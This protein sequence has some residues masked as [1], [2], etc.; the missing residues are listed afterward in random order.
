M[1]NAGDGTHEH[2]TQALLDIMTIRE[3]LG[4]VEDKTIAIVGDILHSRVARSNALALTTL[5]AHVRLIGP[6][7]LL[8]P[9]FDRRGVERYTDLHAGLDGVDAIMMLRLQ[10]ERQTRNFFPSL[11]EYARHFCLTV[12]ALKQAKPEVIILHPGPMNRGVEID[13]RVADG[14]YSVILEQVTN[15]VAVRMAVLYLLTTQE[16]IAASDQPAQASEL[17]TR[18]GQ[19]KQRMREER[20]QRQAKD[21]QGPRQASTPLSKRAVGQ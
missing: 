16:R 20:S 19:V 9:E 17:E 15:G 5:G 13:S 6:P 1:I 3:H 21:G 11:D 12:D 10:R 4:E 2:P 7:T 18:N 8:P 14:P